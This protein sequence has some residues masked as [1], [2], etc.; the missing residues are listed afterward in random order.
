MIRGMDDLTDRWGPML[1][2]ELRQN[3]RRQSFVFPFLCVQALA[4]AAIIAEFQLGDTSVYVGPESM[5]N[6][7]LLGFSGPLWGVISLVCG[8]VMPLGGLV[9]MS[10]ELEEGN[11]ELL[12]LTSLNRWKIVRGKFFTLWGLCVLTFVSLLPYVIVRYLVGS[13]ELVREIAC[14]LTVLACSSMMVAGAIGSSAFLSLLSK[15]LMM[16]LFTGS[17]TISAAISI[18]AITFRS[19]GTGIMYYLHAIA[20]PVSFTLIG[21]ALARS[22]L[23]LAVAAY[24]VKPSSSMIGLLIFAP[25]IVMMSAATTL[26]YGS[27]IGLVAIAL[28][29]LFND[30]SP[31]APAW[32]PPPR[33]NI[34]PTPPAAA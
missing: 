6:V 22:R 31:K 18:A 27:I 2:K 15:T 14:S 26:G 20:V 5:M 1:V 10:Q 7:W 24:E 28:T 30:S 16:L 32:V 12:Q 9:L 8:L 29:A 3:M 13:I 19:G 34:P 21:L 25:F 11:H 23:R 17:T 33:P 4:V